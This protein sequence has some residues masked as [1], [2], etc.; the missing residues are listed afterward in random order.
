LALVSFLIAAAIVLAQDLTGRLFGRQHTVKPAPASADMPDMAMPDYPGGMP[1]ETHLLRQVQLRQDGRQLIGPYRTLNDT[2]KAGPGSYM[3]GDRAFWA[4][5]YENDRV[6]EAPST[7]HYEVW[8]PKP[9]PHWLRWPVYLG[10][11]LLLIPG[12]RRYYDAH[13]LSNNKLPYLEGLRGLA[14]LIVVIT[15]FLWLFYWQI[16]LPEIEGKAW[17]DFVMLHR[18]VPFASLLNA[19]AFAVDTFFVLSGFVLFL[20]FAG[21][22]H[23]DVRRL[24]EAILRR[25]VRLLGILWAIMVVVWMLRQSGLYFEDS[26]VPPKHWTGFLQDLL[27]P[28]SEASDY[29]GPFWTI[30]YELWGSFLIYA[31][32]LV[33]GGRQLRWLSYPFLIWALRHDAYVNFVVGALLADLFRSRTLPSSLAWVRSL[34]PVLFVLAL[35]VGLQMDHA[36]LRQGFDHWLSQYMPDFSIVFPYRKHG[37]VGAVML[38]SALLLSPRIQRRFTHPWLNSLGRQSYA[39]YGAHHMIIFTFSIWV[40]LILMP[41]HASTSKD[42]V[43]HTG[44]YHLAVLVTFVVYLVAV[45]AVSLV[46]TA[47]I[48]EPCIRL[49]QRLAKWVMRRKNQPAAGADAAPERSSMVTIGGTVGGPDR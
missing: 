47:F 44:V 20:P 7:P 21:S 13:P 39:V 22:G 29:C 16:H 10:L 28:Y 17:Y 25:P 43:P 18:N 45:W 9:V 24:M 32:A 27:R 5:P 12:V 46:I 1:K 41:M 3:L 30:G 38:I 48:D 6:P 33:L 8:I 4:I 19:G 35:L 23:V 26:H 34:A 31:F 40:L 49:S 37:L 36:S 14:C 42:V 2:R 11:I 15:H